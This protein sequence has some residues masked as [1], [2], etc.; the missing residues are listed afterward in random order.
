MDKPI[1]QRAAEFIGRHIVPPS[2]VFNP[3]TGAADVVPAKYSFTG[4][5]ASELE[6][7]ARAASA[8]SGLVPVPEDLTADA[9]AQAQAASAPPGSAPPGA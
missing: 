6:R 2:I 4:V 1:P 3:D 9:L 7:I 8:A 5:Y